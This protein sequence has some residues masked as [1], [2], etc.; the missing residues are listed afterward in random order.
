MALADSARPAFRV[1]GGLDRMF[2][3]RRSGF[4]NTQN[5][6]YALVLFAAGFAIAGLGAFLTASLRQEGTKLPWHLLL[7]S[8]LCAVTFVVYA[9]T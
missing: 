8:V 1:V 6:T 2:G 7:A 3:V 9:A 5:L 4:G